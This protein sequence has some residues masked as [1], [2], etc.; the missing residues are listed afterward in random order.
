MHDWIAGWLTSGDSNPCRFDDSGLSYVLIRIKKTEDFDYLFLQ[1]CF[2]KNGPVWNAS[3]DYVGI[4]CRKDGLLYNVK[5]RFIRLAG[6]QEFLETRSCET[7]REK[8]RASVRKKVEK[9]IDGDRRN[10]QITELTDYTLI[11]QLQYDLE[12]GAKEVAR[13]Y[14]LDTSD[15]KLPIFTC[16]Y[17]PDKF[18]EDS[19]LAYVRDPK[20]FVD[21]ETVKYIACSQEKMLYSF[22][23]NDAVQKEYKEILADIE[24][25]VH[26]IK[27]IIAAMNKNSA[28]TVN[29]TILKNGTEFTFKTGA[30]QL[31][32]DCVSYYSTFDMVASD[33]R[34]FDKLFGRNANYTPEEILRITYSRRVL[35]EA[36][37]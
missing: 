5:S 25:P 32:V 33:R 21:R 22:L 28:K 10:L 9:I 20:S 29:V 13:R 30:S 37:N 4:Y 15:S 27:K 8:L 36:H 26:L 19:F 16:S 1:S 2:G 23:R 11:E 24:N 3:F 18:D 31:R 7:L 17:S 12:Y 14:F 35:Y 6:E 34:K